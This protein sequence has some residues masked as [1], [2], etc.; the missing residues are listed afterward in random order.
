MGRR[1]QALSP[2][3]PTAEEGSL[4]LTAPVGFGFRVGDFEICLESSLQRKQRLLWDDEFFPAAEATCFVT[5]EGLRLL[6]YTLINEKPL[7]E[8][9]TYSLA[10]TVKRRDSMWKR[11]NVRTYW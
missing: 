2:L 4:V 3:S 1:L 5:G 9:V 7:L 8:G 10:S 6:T 11:H